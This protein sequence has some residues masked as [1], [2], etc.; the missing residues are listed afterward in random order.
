MSE[1]VQ[2]AGF[3]W[4]AD[5]THC[6]AVIHDELADLDAALAL[7]P[8]R[9]VAVQAGGNV[10]VWAAHLA[11]EFET[12]M[13]FEP[14][15]ENYQCLVKN[16]PT[17]VRFWQVGL[18]DKPGKVGMTIVPGNA[19]A[20][21]IGGAGEIEIITLDS[22]DLPGCDFLCLDVE[23]AEPLALHGAAETIRK[24]RPVVMMEE[25]GLS[26]R[27]FGIRRGAAERWLV[28]EHGYRVAMKVRKDLILVPA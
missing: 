15:A 6:H 24:F 9:K 25:K 21:Y 4:P 12:V 1:F 8:G 23:G 20:H 13:T 18:G 2:H 28:R 26:E 22:L 17:N 7:V 19:G 27:Y 5:D 3:W 10:G 16:V 11:R 14:V